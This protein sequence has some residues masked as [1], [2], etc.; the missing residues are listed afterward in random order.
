M[1]RLF[2]CA[3]FFSPHEG[4]PGIWDVNEFSC[5]S[6]E[7]SRSGVDDN[8][9]GRLFCSGIM[10]VHAQAPV[11]QNGC[12]LSGKPGPGGSYE[13]RHPDSCKTT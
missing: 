3:R 7:F 11:C 5:A 9:C 13:W 6:G 12:C 8:T 4:T 1:S 10:E 2:Y